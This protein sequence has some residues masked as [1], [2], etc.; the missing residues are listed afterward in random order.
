M[1][2]VDLGNLHFLN[3]DFLSNITILSKSKLEVALIIF[4]LGYTL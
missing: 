3:S 2:C 1:L 4:L